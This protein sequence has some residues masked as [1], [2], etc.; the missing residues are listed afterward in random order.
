MVTAQ[1]RSILAA[2]RKITKARNRATRDAIKAQRKPGGKAD[3]GRER[4]NGHLAFV[5]RL[6]C[7]ATYIE[8]GQLL[9]GCQAAHLRLSSAAHGKTEGGQRKPSDCWVTPLSPE[10]HRIQGEVKGETRF[11]G[12]L[13]LD[14]FDLCK[15]LYAVSG[16][17]AAAITVIR[18][19]RGAGA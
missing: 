17:E 15:R 10:Q 14:P 11:W 19:Y 2:A 13:G 18:S 1:E 5:R 8:T 7:V 9:Y 16:D 12:D 6:P 4:D 3:R